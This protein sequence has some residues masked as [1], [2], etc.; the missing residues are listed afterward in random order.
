MGE[1]LYTERLVLLLTLLL[2]SSRNHGSHDEEEGGRIDNTIRRKLGG[3]MSPGL[4][5][6]ECHGWVCRMTVL[7]P[8][9]W[10]LWE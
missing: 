4:L 7:F 9:A 2:F 1:S 6:A 5:V 3:E 10:F 8:N